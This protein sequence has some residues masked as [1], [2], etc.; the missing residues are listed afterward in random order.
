MEAFPL[1]GS[2]ATHRGCGFAPKIEQPSAN[3]K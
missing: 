1:M 2:A 3:E